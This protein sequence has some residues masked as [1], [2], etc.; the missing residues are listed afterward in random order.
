METLSIKS[1]GIIIYRLFDAASEIDLSLI[2]LKTKEETKRLRLSKHPYT[3][4]LEFAN[5][6]VSFELSSFTKPFFGQDTK[7]V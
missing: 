2:E 3:K 5:P 7:S 1:G 6:P 4:A